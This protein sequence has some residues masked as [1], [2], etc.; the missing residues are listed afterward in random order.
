[1][2]KPEL[3]IVAAEP[4][5][6]I[7]AVLVPAGLLAHA[8]PII[9]P[10]VR[11]CLDQ[12]RGEQTEESVRARMASGE[13][14]AILF[15]AGGKLVGFAVIQIAD[16][17]PGRPELRLCMLWRDP[18]ARDVDR[19]AVMGHID[20]VARMHGCK[21]IVCGS[22]RKADRAGKEFEAVMSEFGYRP[23]YVTY[24]KELT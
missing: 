2:S 3:K 5:P 1:M 24:V 12:T 21:A 14:Q 16:P 18:T 11:E 17:L 9:L 8:W 7:R 19:P 23:S 10:G 13:A 6:E 20:G 15:L 4:K 22:A